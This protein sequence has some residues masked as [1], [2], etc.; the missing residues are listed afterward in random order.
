MKDFSKK[1]INVLEN[2]IGL[3]PNSVEFIPKT[4]P[5]KRNKPNIR[6]MPPLKEIK[7]INRAMPALKVNKSTNINIHSKDNKFVNNVTAPLREKKPIINNNHTKKYDNSNNKNIINTKNDNNILCF[8]SDELNLLDGNNLNKFSNEE[9]RILSLTDDCVY[10][11]CYVNLL[12][13]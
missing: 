13:K 3:N 6:D 4:L 10:R 7:S 9:I 11:C 5:T 1:N 2:K 8:S 12:N